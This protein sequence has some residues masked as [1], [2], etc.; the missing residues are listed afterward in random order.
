MQET[1]KNTLMEVSIY[2]ETAINNL[3][4]EWQPETAAIPKGQ[5]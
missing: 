4:S 2:R 5:Y 3:K 1:E